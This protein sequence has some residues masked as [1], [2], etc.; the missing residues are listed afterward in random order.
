VRFVRKPDNEK[1]GAIGQDAQVGE[2]LRRD[3]IATPGDY[4]V[5]DTGWLMDD[6]IFASLRR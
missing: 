2:E 3:E 6:P 1:T 5:L 4:F